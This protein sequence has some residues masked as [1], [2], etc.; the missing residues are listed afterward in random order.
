VEIIEEIAEQAPD[1]V[2][3][4]HSLET[5]LGAVRDKSIT[6]IELVWILA[7]NVDADGLIEILIEEFGLKHAKKLMLKALRISKKQKRERRLNNKSPLCN[8]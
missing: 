6:Q 5:V 8:K 7:N 3:L 1:D 4:E 2:P